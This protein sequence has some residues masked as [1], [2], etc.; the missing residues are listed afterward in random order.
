MSLYKQFFSAIRNGNK[1]AVESLLGNPECN[2]NKCDDSGIFALN[3]ALERNEH[4]IAIMIAMHPKLTIKLKVDDIDHPFC[5]ACMFDN[6]DVALILLERFNLDF[7]GENKE[8][9]L[10]EALLY[11]QTSACKLE[12]RFEDQQD[13]LVLLMQKLINH[14]TIDVNALI[15]PH[16]NPWTLLCMCRASP[17]KSR[18]IDVFLNCSRVNIEFVSANRRNVMFYL[19]ASGCVHDL[20][21]VCSR[22]KFNINAIDVYGKT[23]MQMALTSNLCDDEEREDIV[24]FLLEQPEIDL[25]FKCGDLD[26]S[27]L[28]P[29]LA[30]ILKPKMP[31]IFSQDE[32]VQQ[33]ETVVQPEE[34]VV[35]SEQ[36]VSYLTRIFNAFG[37][38]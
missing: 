35:Q 3:C 14:P 17:L 31:E 33:K 9:Q 26:Y 18:L 25:D 1:S 11:N 16:H 30:H 32:I 27:Q 38:Y 2:V 21:N 37:Y 36:N 24:K 7:T 6:I 19:C 5:Y 34:T 28:C 12:H 23:P 15:G 10:F 22:A 20:R 29:S 8:V 13:K 4:T